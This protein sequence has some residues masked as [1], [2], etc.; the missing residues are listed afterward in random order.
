MGWT[1]NACVANTSMNAGKIIASHGRGS[2]IIVMLTWCPWTSASVYIVN[3][4][5]A[6]L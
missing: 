3:K 2:G 6:R 5:G 4:E 1:V